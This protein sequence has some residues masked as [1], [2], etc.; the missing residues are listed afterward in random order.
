M[1]DFGLDLETVLKLVRMLLRGAAYFFAGFALLGLST[2]VVFLCREIF[3]SPLRTKVRNAKVPQ[4]AGCAPVAEE[5]PEPVLAEKPIS[6]E[7]VIPTGEKWGVRADSGLSP[8]VAARVIDGAFTNWRRKA[9]PLRFRKA[10]EALIWLAGLG[11]VAA[12][13]ALLRQN[14]SLQESLAPQ[15]TAG[16]HLE[17]LAGL[18]VDGHLQPIALP[19]AN[20]KLLII[21]FSPG[22][23]AC[24]A[25]QEG[26]MKLAGALEPKGVRALWVS[27]DPMEVTRDY[28]L[29]HGIPLSDVLA[30]PPNRTYVQLGLARV[31]NTVLVRADGMV[32]KV[33]AGQQDQAGWDTMFVYFGEREETASP[34]AVAVGARMPDCGSELSLS[35]VKNCK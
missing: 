8:H 10:L 21:T 2:Y 1:G 27:R 15:I 9:A 17:K 19:P 16:V 34:T 7:E 11:V 4:P 24:Q 32:E 5:S 35:S 13:M 22:C 29:K 28:C 12:N 14:R 31:P 18:A 20:S 26:W 25:N 6:V 30:D 23:P 3:A 33:W